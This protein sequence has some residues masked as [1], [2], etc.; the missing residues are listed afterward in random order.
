MAVTKLSV[1]VDEHIAQVV[2]DAA[3][4]DGVSVSAWFSEAASDRI[5]NE[6]LEEALAE[7]VDHIGLSEAEMQAHVTDLRSRS[8]VTRPEEGA[9]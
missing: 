4:R 1:S 7:F 6:L 9:A 5:R 3:A 2:R 8:F